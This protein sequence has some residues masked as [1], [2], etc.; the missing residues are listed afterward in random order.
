MNDIKE[1]YKYQMFIQDNDGHWYKIFVSDRDKFDE[2]V[3][4]CE[5]PSCQIEEDDYTGPDFDKFRC[6]HPCNYMSSD[7]RVLKEN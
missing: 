4:L 1:L 3:E 7:I 2:W 5:K 6:M